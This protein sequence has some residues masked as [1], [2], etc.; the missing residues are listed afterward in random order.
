MDNY[1]K[2]KILKIDKKSDVTSITA[3]CMGDSEIVTLN[4]ATVLSND[5]SIIKAE[6]IRKYLAQTTCDL[7]VGEII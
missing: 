6:L 5:R 2:F 1:F 7:K 4:I 3:E